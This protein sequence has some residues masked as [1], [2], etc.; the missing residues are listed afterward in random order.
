MAFALLQPV[1]LG[2]VEIHPETHPLQ[3]QKKYFLED[4]EIKISGHSTVEELA[5]LGDRA[6][7]IVRF[8]G[9]NMSPL[10]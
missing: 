5:Q 9:R 1:G 6:H 4:M 10:C 8:S 3:K 2:R 7:H